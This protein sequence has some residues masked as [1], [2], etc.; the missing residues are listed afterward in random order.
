MS[1]IGTVQGAQVGVEVAT[2]MLKTTNDQQ[3]AV[4]QLLEDAVE[5]SDAVGEDGKGEHIDTHA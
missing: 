4:V 5:T 3:K 2:R 1:E